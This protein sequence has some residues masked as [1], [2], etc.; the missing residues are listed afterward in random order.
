MFE[1]ADKQ[2]LLEQ[3][4]ALSKSLVEGTALR[5]DLFT[6]ALTNFL[7]IT[8]PGNALAHEALT[9]H[10]PMDKKQLE[11][12]L[13]KA[14][15]IIVTVATEE[16]EYGKVYTTGQIAKLFGVSITTIHNWLKE[17]RF[18]GIELK[19]GN[20]QTRIPESTRWKSPTGVILTIREVAEKFS[21]P[22][23]TPRTA[24][25]ELLELTK[26]IAFFEQ[27][28]KST[29]EQYLQNQDIE[30]ADFETRRDLQEWKYLQRR[31][32]DREET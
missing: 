8:L 4:F 13:V 25:Q 30:K 18:I 17:G 29:Y 10:N 6:L 2:V 15:E 7:K 20:K 26:S 24:N 16:V 23:Q 9:V 32:G 19:G 28:Y 3:R 12:A 5:G 14:L 27:K 1:A 22:P 31:I 11:D 21:T